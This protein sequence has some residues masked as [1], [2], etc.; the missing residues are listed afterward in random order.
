MSREFVHEICAALPGAEVSAPFG[1][2]HDTWKLADKIFALVDGAGE[3][4]ITKCPDVDTAEMLKEVGLAQK[5]PYFHKSWV[6]L[7]FDRVEPDELRHRILFRSI[8][9]QTSPQAPARSKDGRRPTLPPGGRM[10]MP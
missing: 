6:L 8:N 5:A 3:S 7:P 1:G 10:E 9:D 4:V 2:G